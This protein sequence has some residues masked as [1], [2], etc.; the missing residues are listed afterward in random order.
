MQKYNLNAKGLHLL[1][2]H[3]IHITLVFPI[4]LISFFFTAEYFILGSHT[5]ATYTR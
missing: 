1:L 5:R 3:T 4:V 2:E